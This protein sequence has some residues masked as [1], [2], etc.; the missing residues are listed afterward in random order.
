MLDG[1]VSKMKR[2]VEM[3][4][5]RLDHQKRDSE[6]APGKTTDADCVCSPPELKARPDPAASSSKELLGQLWCFPGRRMS[7]KPSSFWT[8]VYMSQTARLAQPGIETRTR[9]LYRARRR[10]RHPQAL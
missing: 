3:D 2:K 4:D 9:H 8:S 6:S 1:Y 5:E 10:R 7:E